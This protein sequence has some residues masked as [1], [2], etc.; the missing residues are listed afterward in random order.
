[1]IDLVF[2]NQ[3]FWIN[4]IA[5]LIAV[6]VMFIM[7]KKFHILEALAQF[8]ATFLV[9]LIV[10]VIGFETNFELRDQEVWNGNIQKFVYYE[11][12]KELVH[13]TVQV[14][15][16]TDSK[17]NTRYRTEFRTRIDYHSPRW[18]IET[19][20]GGFY[21]SKEAFKKAVSLYGSIFVD[22]NRFSQVS[23]GDGNKYESYPKNIIAVSK[24]NSYINYIRAS[25]YTILKKRGNEEAIQMYI[26]FGRFIPY[27]KL[28]SGDFSQDY[29]FRVINTAKFNKPI[30]NLEKKLSEFC[31]KYSGEKQFNLIVYI[32][33]N[34]NADFKYALEEYWKSAHKNDT[35]IIF[36]IDKEGLIEWA[37][38]ISWTERGDYITE[39]KHFSGTFGT[40]EGQNNIYKQITENIL[41]RW[42]RISMEK[43]EYLKSDLR[44]P[45]WFQIMVLFINIITNTILFF[46]FL[47][48]RFDKGDSLG[49]L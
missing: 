2:R 47:K 29:F 17:G 40:E 30:I 18:E 4:I 16:G 49:D 13:Y 20:I 11:E 31:A 24:W 43:F 26:K 3:I 10:Y 34:V 22:M 37:D 5:T 19:T 41:N 12:W 7:K 8:V 1:M 23:H 46:V 35:I 44:L 27:P 9:L 36:S 48:N 39:I 15:A 38:T 45:T 33:S 28:S 25:R 32:T 14:P 42:E 6:V 21:S